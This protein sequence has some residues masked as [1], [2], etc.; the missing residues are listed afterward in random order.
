[1]WGGPETPE[2]HAGVSNTYFPVAAIELRR[3]IMRLP[4]KSVSDSSDGGKQALSEVLL[5]RERRYFR[6]LVKTC[7]IGQIVRYSQKR[8]HHIDLAQAGF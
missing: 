7:Q 6:C 3:Q 5:D 4:R 1:V 2:G 8:I